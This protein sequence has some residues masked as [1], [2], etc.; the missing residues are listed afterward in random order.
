MTKHFIKFKLWLEVT[1]NYYYSEHAVLFGIGWQAHHKNKPHALYT[2]QL[3]FLKKMLHITIVP[4][5][6][7]YLKKIN[8]STR[9]EW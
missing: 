3:I 5:Y 2:V 9:C 4:N 1:R 8:E 6:R 7:A